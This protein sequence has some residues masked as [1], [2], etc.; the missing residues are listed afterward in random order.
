MVLK[1]GMAP[2]VSTS[3]IIGSLCQLLWCPQHCSIANKQRYLVGL[4]NI[5]DFF[6]FLAYWDY[7]KQKTGLHSIG[8]TGY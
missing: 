7:L 4:S 2:A 1:V 8:K 3:S 5:V 6:D